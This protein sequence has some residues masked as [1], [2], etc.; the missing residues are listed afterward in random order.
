MSQPN[1]IIVAGVNGAGK[2]TLYEVRPD[3]FEGSLRINADEL[4]KES[5]GDWHNRADNFRAMM[6]AGNKLK[7]AI[8]GRIDVH[9]ETTLAVARNTLIREIDFAKKHGFKVSLLYVAVSDVHIAINRI[10]VRVA[11]GGHGVDAALVNKRYTKSLERLLDIMNLVDTVQ[12]YVNDT[13]FDLVYYSEDE[14]VLLDETGTYPWLS[15][16]RKIL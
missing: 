8:A 1:F 13:S 3:L 2:T 11:K 15:V 14:K 16:S 5:G 4:L 12:I 7:S 10:L 9:Q 6:E